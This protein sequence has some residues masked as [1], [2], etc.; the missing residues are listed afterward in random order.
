MARLLSLLTGPRARSLVL[1]AL[2]VAMAVVFLR[3][4][5][6]SYAIERWLFWHYAVYWLACAGWVAGVVRL[7][8]L[9]VTRGFRLTLPLHEA[10]VLALAVGL[11]EFEL[12]M[13][14]LGVV[15]AFRTPTFFL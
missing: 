4:V 15:H 12:A 11:F 14:G 2:L 10:T 5:N 6:T 1:A 9:T 7:G 13:L 3:V 8:H